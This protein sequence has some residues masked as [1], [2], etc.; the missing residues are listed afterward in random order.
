MSRRYF[1]SIISELQ[2]RLGL[3]VGGRSPVQSSETVDPNSLSAISEPAVNTAAI[4]TF[5]AP[6]A[7][8]RL[9]VRYIAGFYTGGAPTLQQLTIESPAATFKLRYPMGTAA[10]APKEPLNGGRLYGAV[11]A[12]VVVTLPAAG[13]GVSGKLYAT[14]AVVR[15]QA[16]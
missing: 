16:V 9:V 7:G 14:A 11:N 8:L 5:A 6:G 10:D 12:A 2:M 4:I 13:V 1:E 3:T 15:G